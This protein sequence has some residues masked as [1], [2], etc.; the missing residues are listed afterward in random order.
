MLYLKY[1]EINVFFL[2]ISVF[3]S[4]DSEGGSVNNAKDLSLIGITFDKTVGI[5]LNFRYSIYQTNAN[6]IFYRTR[7]HRRRYT[8][9]YMIQYLII[10]CVSYSQER[11]LLGTCQISTFQHLCFVCSIRIWNEAVN[12]EFVIINYILSA[13][14]K[15][16]SL[17]CECSFHCCLFLVVLLL[18]ARLIWQ[19]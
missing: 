2:R 12:G 9:I 7:T 19:R 17:S 10:S 11:I 18:P 4:D 16:Y 8:I 6:S 13:E 14:I 1:I 3:W 15:I 5:F